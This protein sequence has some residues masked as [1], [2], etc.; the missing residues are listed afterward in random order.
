MNIKAKR[1]QF[2]NALQI[3]GINL[4]CDYYELTHHQ[5]LV[6]DEVR[7]NFGY[8]GKNAAGREPSRQFYYAAQKGCQ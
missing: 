3:M 2:A 5:Q 7:K 6:V 4:N 1:K 8:S